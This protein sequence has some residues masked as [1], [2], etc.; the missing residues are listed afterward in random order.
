[1]KVSIIT[2]WLQMFLASD[3]DYARPTCT[4]LFGLVET[5]PIDKEVVSRMWML[6]CAKE[7][8]KS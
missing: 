3:F 8:A 1:M 5:M 6:S 7:F 4:S 2:K